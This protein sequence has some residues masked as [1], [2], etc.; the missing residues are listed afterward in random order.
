MVTPDCVPH[1]NT[2][3]GNCSSL[4]ESRVNS[5]R[6][7]TS[8]VFRPH[9]LLIKQHTGPMLSWYF[10]CSPRYFCEHRI[11]LG[12]LYYC[13]VSVYIWKF[14]IFLQSFLNFVSRV[15]KK[16]ILVYT[17]LVPKWIWWWNTR[18]CVPFFIWKS[19]TLHT[20]HWYLQSI[21]KQ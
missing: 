7:T 4:D 15:L 17:K 5:S 8:S 10:D 11:F 14:C 19:L 3:H 6:N 20:T 9:D 2:G 18:V 13:P 1:N 21:L 12:L 16:G